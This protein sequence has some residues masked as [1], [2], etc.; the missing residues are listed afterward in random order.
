VTN[1]LKRHVKLV[2]KPLV[3]SP[4]VSSSTA[5]RGDDD[6]QVDSPPKK[7]TMF[8][9]MQERASIFQNAEV[10]DEVDRYFSLALE[11]A[12]VDPLVFWKLHEGRFSNLAKLSKSFLA[13]PA[14][15]G[16]VERLFSVAGALG[17][18][19]RASI[20]VPNMEKSLCV[21]QYMINK[22]NV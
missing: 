6:V 7:K 2:S 14:S 12:T 18:C 3:T 4:N 21:R 15:S 11:P 5:V 19:R 1:I 8:D 17:R 13:M 9:R 16:A 20:T 10:F 22:Y